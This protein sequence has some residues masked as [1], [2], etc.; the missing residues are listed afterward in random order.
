[1]S[2]KRAVGVHADD[3]AAPRRQVAHHLA[4]AIFRAAETKSKIKYQVGTMIELPR[5][6]LGGGEIAETA[7]FFSSAP[8]T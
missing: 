2:L 8:T 6:A 4:H 5:A 3:F 7:E 1:M